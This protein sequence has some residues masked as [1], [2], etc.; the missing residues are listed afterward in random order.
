MQAFA[1]IFQGAFGSLRAVSQTLVQATP[2]MFT[3]LAFAIAKKASLINIGVEG[4]MDMGA[5]AAAWIG[6]MPLPPPLFVHSN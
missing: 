4:Q 6:A 3:G 1:A 2:L 5:I